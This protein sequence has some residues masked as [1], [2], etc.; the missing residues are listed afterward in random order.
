MWFLKRQE[1][2]DVFQDGGV[3]QFCAA[4]RCD[5]QKRYE[6]GNRITR[7]DAQK[8][9]DEIVLDGSRIAVAFDDQIAAD[10]KEAGDGKRAER[11]GSGDSVENIAARVAI[12]EEVG[13]VTNNKIGEKQ[14]QNAKIVFP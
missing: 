1:P 13:V 10:E 8:A 11:H 2:K 12:N 9:F 7:P 5:N 3:R 14:A 4:Q 6:V